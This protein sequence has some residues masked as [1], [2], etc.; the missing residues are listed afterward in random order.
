[1]AVE[2]VVAIVALVLILMWA[3]FTAQRLNSLHIRTDAALAQLEATL[4]RRAAVVAALA[5]E[6]EEVASRAESSELTQGHFETRSAHERELSI[7]VNER[8]AERPALLADA[9]GR[10]HLAHRFYNEAVSD[11]RSLRLR[12]LVRMFRLGGTA[13]LPEFFELSQLRI[14]E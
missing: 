3:Y 5:P 9:E 1:M 10:I 6:L 13:P 11:T 12:P 4:D 7:A 2:L 8:F 14:T